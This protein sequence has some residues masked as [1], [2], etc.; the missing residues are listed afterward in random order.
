MHLFYLLHANGA[1]LDPR[2]Q[3]TQMA[4]LDAGLDAGADFCK[5]RLWNLL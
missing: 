3:N 4:H 1:M 5:C 2:L